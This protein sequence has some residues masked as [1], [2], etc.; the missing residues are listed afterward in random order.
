M[1]TKSEMI[2]RIA[3]LAKENAA[4]K[5]LVAQRDASVT[6]QTG[7]ILELK[8]NIEDLSKD[9]KV[10]NKIIGILEAE[11]DRLE[12]EN[13]TANSNAAR[14]KEENYQLQKDCQI[15]ENFIDFIPC[16]PIRDMDYDLQKVI[17]Q[18]DKYIQ[19]L[20]EIKA[21]IPEDYKI[22]QWYEDVIQLITKAE[23]E[24]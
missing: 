5:A 18:R 19:T 10:Q 11:N 15:C 14:L 16:K 2:N 7:I 17:N 12:A 20:Q 21:R 8:E 4:L 6:A 9:L 3:E 1:Q 24:G 23:S 13:A 22:Y